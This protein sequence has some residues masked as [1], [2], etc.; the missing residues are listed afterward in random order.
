MTEFRRQT[1]VAPH[2]EVEDCGRIVQEIGLQPGVVFWVQL[3]HLPILLLQVKG[4]H[5]PVQGGLSLNVLVHIEGTVPFLGPLLGTRL[6][7]LL[8]GLGFGAL[9]GRLGHLAQ[10]TWQK[11]R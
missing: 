8:M 2:G 3:S 5:S 10:R 7:S 4:Q 6:R 11:S 9:L 1:W